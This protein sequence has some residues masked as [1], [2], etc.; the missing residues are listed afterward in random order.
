VWVDNRPG[1]PTQ[2]EKYYFV[3]W[4]NHWFLQ[5]MPA[6]VRNMGMLWALTGEE[7]YAHKA[8]VL[9][10]RF[11]EVYPDMDADDLTYDG[12]DWGVYIK[13]LP[14]MW[15]GTAHT[16]IV[17]CVEFHPAH[18]RRRFRGRFHQ[19]CSIPHLR[20]TRPSPRPR[21]GAM[22]GTPLRALCQSHRRHRYPRLH[23]VGTPRGGRAD[24]DNQYF[25]DGFPYEAAFGYGTH[26]MYDD[27]KIADVMGANGNGFGIILTC[28]NLSKVSRNS[29]YSTNTRTSSAI[30]GG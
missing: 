7:R 11:M 15:E 3:G 19:A 12:T 24:L 21:T 25:R 9:I 16:N 10:E 29:S 6:R 18:A 8:R 5:S 20:H 30:R 22:S 13:M 23:C 14:T 28:G 27:H 1:S 2:G 17:D 26:Y 4:F